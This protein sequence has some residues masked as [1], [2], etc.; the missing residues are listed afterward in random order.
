M[1]ARTV[2]MSTAST[3]IERAQDH[4]GLT[5]V[6]ISESMGV[7]RRTV[8]RWKN[9]AVAPNASNLDRLEKIRVLENLLLDVFGSE[10][11]ALEWFHSPVDGF[12][13]RSPYALFRS[14][15][16][17]ELIEALASHQSGAFV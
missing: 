8:T 3:T 12:G 17:D 6:D 10:E 14:G 13:G 4:L 9:K 11:A 7:N 2:R 15:R 16:L 1:T 5:S